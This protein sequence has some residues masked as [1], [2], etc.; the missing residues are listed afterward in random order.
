MEYLLP[1]F[2]HV[3]LARGME[4]LVHSMYFEPRIWSNWYE[5]S[6]MSPSYGVA[7]SCVMGTIR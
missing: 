5:A 3:L 6:V 4:Y 1:S 2:K 7:E